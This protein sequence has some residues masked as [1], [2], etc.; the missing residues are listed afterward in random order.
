[1]QKVSLLFLSRSS[2]VF[3]SVQLVPLKKNIHHKALLMYETPF[4][5][6]EIH[7][8]VTVEGHHVLSETFICPCERSVIC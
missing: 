2:P 4:L 1:M 5:Y 7:T 3:L 6:S 8:F